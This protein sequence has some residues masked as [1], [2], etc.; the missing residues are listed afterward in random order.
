MLNLFKQLI[1]EPMQER[2]EQDP[3]NLLAK[4]IYGQ[5]AY[6]TLVTWYDTSNRET[7]I[8][9]GYRGN[10]SMYSIVNKIGTKLTEV[11]FQI[12][13]SQSSKYKSQKFSGLEIKTAESRVTRKKEMDLVES[14]PLVDLLAQPN[15]FSN[16]TEFLQDISMFWNVTGEFFIYGMGPKI[17]RDKGKYQ[18]LW[19]LPSHLVVLVQGDMWQPV[20]GYKLLIGDQSIQIPAEDVLH[21]KRPNPVWDLQGSQLRGQPPM[22]AGIKYLQKNN[23]AIT[24]LQKAMQNEG[25][26]G[27][28]S[29]DSS[30]P[31]LW[32]GGTAMADIKAGLNKAIN[33]SV[34]KNRVGAVGI[35]VKYTEIGL[36]PVALAILD[37]MENDFD[38][39]C[40]IYSVNPALFSKDGKYDNY[41]QAKKSLVTDVCVP[42]F[43]LLEQKL[44]NWL[45]PRFDG[46]Y[47]DMDVTVYSELQP[48]AKL[49]IDTYGKSPAFTWNELRTMLNWE[50]S[51]DAGANVHWVPNNVLP[52]SEALM[53][54]VI[55]DNSDFV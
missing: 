18:E 26:K 50:T 27:F 35:P 15:R 24:A 16:W 1:T 45:S 21:V 22:L 49:I 53:G 2:N 5:F 7:F 41:E 33:G 25:A 44:N 13:K 14:G 55:P 28:V 23:E 32:A 17:G 19:V 39:M 3:V 9:Q 54:D 6:N 29:P 52:S 8:N 48:D 43:N 36:S 11:P 12:F 46:Q 38:T 10:A 42:F 51:E 40:N 47:V 4:I 20:K 34:N 30:N 31:E 37:G